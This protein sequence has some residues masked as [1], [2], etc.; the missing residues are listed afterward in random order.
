MYEIKSAR[1]RVR[2]RLALTESTGLNFRRLLV[3]VDDMKHEERFDKRNVRFIP[4][5]MVY[6]P[7]FGVELWAGLNGQS[8]GDTAL[9]GSSR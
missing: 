6:N 9:V 8:N 7:K 5:M 2:C 1:A 3:I 4:S